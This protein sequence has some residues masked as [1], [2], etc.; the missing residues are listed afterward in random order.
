MR[1]EGFAVLD[2]ELEG[3]AADVTDQDFEVVGIDLGVLG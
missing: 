3:G 1:A 2:G